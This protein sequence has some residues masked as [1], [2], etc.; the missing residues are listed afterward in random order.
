MP[1]K[2]PDIDPLEYLPYRYDDYTPISINSFNPMSD[3]PVLISG[4][5]Q[6]VEEIKTENGKM[7]VV[8]LEV[9]GG[10]R[11][12]A[13]YFYYSAW[14]MT[15]FKYNKDCVY[16]FG[17]PRKEAGFWSMIF[18]DFVDKDDVGKLIPVYKTKRGISQKR[19]RQHVWETVQGQRPFLE[20]E[21]PVETLFKRGLPRISTALTQIHNPIEMPS[22]EPFRRLAYR[23]IYQIKKR[24]LSIP[25]AQAPVMMKVDMTEFY[26]SLPFNPTAGQISAI[27]DIACDMAS[28]TAMRRILVGDVG[29]GKTLV[30]K[31]A[32][33]ICMKNSYRTLVMSPTTVL[34]EQTCEKFK[35]IFGEENVSLYTGDEKETPAMIIIGTHA[36]L[37]KKFA[38]VGLVILDESQK[39]GVVQKNK[40][41]GNVHAL[42]MTATPIPRTISL[43]YHGAI[44]LSE[45][46]DM[47][48]QRDVVTSVVSIEDKPK[49]L[50]HLRQIISDGEKALV[51]YPLV[52]ED[53]GIHTAV[54]SKKDIWEK[55]YPGKVA[56]VH[57]K[58]ED[59]VD[60]VSEFR[61]SSD[62]QILVA[63]CLI[64]TGLDC[65]EA[66]MMIISG[67]EKFG[68]SQLHQLRGRIGRRGQKSFCYFMY[69]NAKAQ[70]RLKPLEYVN[71]G[72]TLAEMDS[73]M[74]GWGDVLG[75]EQSGHCF[76]FKSLGIYKDVAPLVHEDLGNAKEDQLCSIK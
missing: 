48:F 36:I 30:A 57:G 52:K 61:R 62:K 74:R 47:P 19:M 16:L 56:W 18:P 68:I 65:P 60:V 5:V 33:Y 28:G 44:E 64:E 40:L 7:L 70:E 38:N 20:D 12:C 9:A 43:L 76:N 32:A 27:E 8:W 46:K 26:R 35:A 63:T 41:L 73:D 17:V 72:F 45:I 34:A 25:K 69:K 75:D 55:L 31:A 58:L 29:C 37:N 23:E 50:G 49:V 15:Y 2:L 11:L 3:K 59:K 6:R 67:A 53:R 42:Q 13:K 10:G 1:K 71:D 51:I 22:A 24:L 39:F 66:S 21:V 14:H 54:E 4:S